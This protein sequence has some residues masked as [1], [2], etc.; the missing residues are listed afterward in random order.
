MRAIHT[1]PLALFVFSCATLFPNAA[2]AH[3]LSDRLERCIPSPTF[4]QEVPDVSVQGRVPVIVV[5]EVVFDG[6]TE[7]PATE[8]ANLTKKL[9]AMRVKADDDG[10]QE[11]QSVI[12]SWWQDHGYY[13]AEVRIN[14]SPT[15]LEAGQQ[16]VSLTIHVDEGDQYRLG[17]VNFRSSEP[18]EPLVFPESQ[19][20]HLVQLQSGDIFAAESIRGTIKALNQL[21][22]SRGYINFVA[23]PI[24]EIDEAAHHRID[25]MLELD[26][27]KQ[28]RLG[29]IE[30]HAAS[31]KVRDAINAQLKS[32]DILDY[33][34]IPKLLKENASALPPD[35]SERDVRLKRDT[36]LGVVNLLFELEPCPQAAPR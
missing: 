22:A 5:D 7:M 12:A 8:R 24:T 18:S 25:L 23:T 3:Q 34:I 9:K 26:Q 20:K 19:L 35:I 31:A 10:L 15:A 21:Y 33:S 2:P 4:A 14:A 28:Y 1:T 30:V 17:S 27:Q 6:V 36:N 13:R 32:G 11:Q 29:S 16:H